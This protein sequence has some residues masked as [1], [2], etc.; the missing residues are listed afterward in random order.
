MTEDPTPPITASDFDPDDATVDAVPTDD[1]ADALGSPHRGQHGDTA[2]TPPT[3]LSPLAEGPG[4]TIGPYKL[5]Q[6]IGEGGFGVVFMAEQTRPV[7]RQVALKIIKLGMDTREVIARFEAERQALAMMDHPNIAR[8]LDAGATDTGRPY[9]VMELV[10]GIPI[11]R[12]CDEQAL[13]VRQRLELFMTVCH[14]VQHAHQKG[15]IHRDL[16]PSNVMVTLHDGKPVPKVIDFGVSKATNQRLTEKTL[17]TQYGAFVGTPQYMSPEQAEMSGLDVDTRADIYSLG[18]MLYE[19]LTGE[20][21]IGVEKLRAT[22]MAEMHTLIQNT[23]IQRP[24]NKLSST[25]SPQEIAQRRSADPKKLGSLIKGDLDWI[26]LKAA[27]KERARRYD[28]A[29][30]LADDI[31]RYLNDEPVHATPPSLAYTLAK[32]A[33]RNRIAVAA[34]GA[35]AAALILGIAG[36]SIGLV[37]A[38]DERAKATAAEQNARAEAERSKNIADFTTTLL[39]A[40]DASALSLEEAVTRAESLF[41]DDHAAA[42]NLL[43]NWGSVLN[44]A[45]EFDRAEEILETALE[46]Q[47]RALGPDHPNLATTYL[48]LA[49]TLGGQQRHAEATEAAARAVEIRESGTEPNPVLIAG[50]LQT[51]LEQVALNNTNDPTLIPIARRI[52]DL[53]LGA[54]GEQHP[55]TFKARAQLATLLYRFGDPDEAIPIYEAALDTARSAAR[56]DDEFIGHLNSL[57]IIYITTGRNSEAGPAFAE[58]I[59]LVVKRNYG[60]TSSV[61]L[62]VANYALWLNEQDRPE[63]AV[64]EATRA[65][66]VAETLGSTTSPTTLYLGRIARLLAR[67][68]RHDAARR[69]YALWIDHADRTTGGDANGPITARTQFAGYLLD[70]GDRDAAVPLAEEAARRA[71][72][73]PAED[74]ARIATGELLERITGSDTDTQPG[75]GATP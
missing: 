73:L 57:V 11:T 35:I 39:T 17:F 38:L 45:A 67:L 63:L 22:G 41:G 1:H 42:G 74:P 65:L 26:V 8:V 46:R 33:K 37:W 21:P 15:V 16:K 5:L 75:T 68:E 59:D 60:G 58:L 6:Q 69:A 50:A 20:T 24:S 34:G 51:Q 31:E 71:E 52:V 23:Q 44:R 53:R 72:D 56:I 3:A 48:A 49:E 19:L 70:Q 55:E 4:Q 10:R 36:T 47:T 12:Y 14:A 32:F 29:S 7:R 40:S 66:D 43:V 28:T 30:G 64:T 27:A 18:I 61:M 9:F 13:T 54:Q 2:A 25:S 62:A